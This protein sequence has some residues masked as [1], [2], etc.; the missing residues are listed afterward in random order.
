MIEEPQRVQPGVHGSLNTLGKVASFVTELRKSHA[1]L[2]THVAFTIRYVTK[3]S[4]TPA[5]NRP[6]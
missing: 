3:N 1:N 4:A 5:V 6:T 2:D